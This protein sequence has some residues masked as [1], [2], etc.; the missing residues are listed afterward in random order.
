M[1]NGIVIKTDGTLDDFNKE[2]TTENLAQSIHVDTVEYVHLEQGIA[3]YVDGEGLLKELSP[4]ITAS[5]IFERLGFPM[6]EYITHYINGHV[7]F[8]GV[9]DEEG[10]DLPLTRDQEQIIRVLAN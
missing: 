1:T 10:N 9:A 4:N 6:A 5:F 7:L 8:V 2:F 3:A